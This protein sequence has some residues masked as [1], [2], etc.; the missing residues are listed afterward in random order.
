MVEWARSNG[1]EPATHHRFIIEHLERVDRGE[2]KKLMVFV[3]PG[4]AKS[5]YCSKLFPP[6][7]LR[8]GN[9]NVLA[10]SCS[11]TLAEQF[12]RWGRNAVKNH[13]LLLGYELRQDSQS[14]GEWETSLNSLYFCAGVG[15]G[16][17]GHRADLGLIDDPIGS[18][19]DADS[20]LIRDKQWDW[21]RNDFIPRLKPGASVIIIMTRRH[22][23]DLAG[24]LLASEGDEWTVINLPMVA[25]ENDQLGRS[26]GQLLWAEWFTQS[27][28]LEAQKDAQTFSSLYQQDPTPAEGDA[29]KSD[30]FVPY[31]ADELAAAGEL[32]F[33]CASDHAV[34]TKQTADLT[35]LIV[36]GVD[37]NNTLWIMPDIWWKKATSDKTVEAMLEMAKRRKPLIWWAEN[38]HISKSIG[39]FLEKRMVEENVFVRIEEV[40]PSRDKLTRAGSIIGRMAMRKVRFPTFANEW[41][42]LARHE[43]LTFPHGKHDDF[44][45]AL[46]HLGAGL[47]RMIG[48]SNAT[49]PK[50][51][52][53]GVERLTWGWVKESDK[54]K[55]LEQELAN[56][57]N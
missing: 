18:Q 49:E 57:D 8:K 13:S 29:F 6:W 24:R 51:R 52:L 48:V 12:G 15:A 23:D 20:K 31:T 44:V 41:W 43:M 45:D 50:R 2:I 4:A 34:S 32:R 26:P 39:P 14:A 28:L 33:Y 11:Y 30:W 36:G 40:T 19:E 22:E 35:C 25:K 38:G 53:G 17:A 47:A 21:Y 37:A 42:P 3:P 27:M 10:C 16:I 1:F 55:K 56:C 9:R 7:F 46:A 5:T 54:R